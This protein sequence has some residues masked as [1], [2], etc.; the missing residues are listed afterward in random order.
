MGLSLFFIIPGHYVLNTPETPTK[1]QSFM[2]CP[3]AG[4]SSVPFVALCSHSKQRCLVL[5]Y[6]MLPSDWPSGKTLSILEYS[7]RWASA[8]Q[9]QMA[10]KVGCDSDVSFRGYASQGHWFSL[11][12]WKA[13][14]IPGSALR[15]LAS[16]LHQTVHQNSR[17]GEWCQWLRMKDTPYTLGFF[18][19][20][21][22]LSL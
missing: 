3:W 21:L 20:R 18:G 10:E 15:H 14:I 17:S 11:I 8:L 7:R 5:R 22:F 6:P 13:C 9:I 1:P 4:L 2:P 19:G 12:I 16:L